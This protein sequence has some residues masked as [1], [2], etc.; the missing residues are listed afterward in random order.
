M[1]LLLGLHIYSPIL[2]ERPKRHNELA[3]RLP[4]IRLPH[5]DGGIPVNA[6]PNGTTSKLAGLFFTLFFS[7]WASTKEDVNT[8]FN[9]FDP[10]WLGIKLEPTAAAADSHHSVSVLA[11]KRIY[12]P[13][14]GGRLSLCK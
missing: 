11:S 2:S 6:F 3:Y 8:D 1:I 13:T 4:A 14:V 9:V 10:T 7:C 5:Q 12:S